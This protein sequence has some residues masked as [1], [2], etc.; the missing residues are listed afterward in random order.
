M[1]YAKHRLFCA[2]VIGATLVQLILYPRLLPLWTELNA[3]CL[4]AGVISLIIY[5]LLQNGTA[6]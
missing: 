1:N 4:V 3:A 2:F 6:K 5:S